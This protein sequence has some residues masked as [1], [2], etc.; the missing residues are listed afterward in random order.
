[1]PISIITPD[2]WQEILAIQTEVYGN[3][4]HE[5]IEVLKSKWLVS[6]ETCLVYQSENRID[7]YLLAHAWNSELPPKLFQTLTPDA[8]GDILFLHDLA[9]SSRAKGLGV[10]GLLVSQLLTIARTKKYTKVILVS[11]QSS[12]AFWSKMG[13]DLV[14]GEIIINSYGDDARVMVF[15]L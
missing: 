10:G 11:V 5:D 8:K 7:A 1:M 12:V 15:I 13:F 14:E 3:G 2:L 4:F 6:P 9:V